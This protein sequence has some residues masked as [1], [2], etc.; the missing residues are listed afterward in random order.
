MSR[1]VKVVFSTKF[2]SLPHVG[3]AVS[4]GGDGGLRRNIRVIQEGH[5]SGDLLQSRI[6]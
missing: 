2:I 3:H 5:V 4:D 1:P 6:E